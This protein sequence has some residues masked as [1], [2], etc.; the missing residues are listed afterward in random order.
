MN[1]QQ[2]LTLVDNWQQWLI[3]EFVLK[4]NGIGENPS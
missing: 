3:L 4:W 2:K 1:Y